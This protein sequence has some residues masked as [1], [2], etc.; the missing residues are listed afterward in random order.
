MSGRKPNGPEWE[1]LNSLQSNLNDLAAIIPTL[2]PTASKRAMSRIEELALGVLRLRASMPKALPAITDT[3][4]ELLELIVAIGPGLNGKAAC[5]A[6][7][8]VGEA[9][10]RTMEEIDPVRT[11]RTV[12]DP[13]MPEAAGRLV[14]IALLAQ[15]RLP[16]AEVGQMYGSGCYAIYYKG[17][18]PY[19]AAV[20]DTETPIYVGKAD[21]ANREARQ[22]R[23]QGPQL[24]GRLRDH[25]RMIMAVEKWAEEHPDP[26]NFP[27]HIADFEYRRLVVATNAQLVAE[28][29]LIQF[30]RP[31]WNREMAICWGISKHGDSAEKRSND[32]APWDVLHPGRAWAMHESLADSKTPD[33]IKSAIDD[34]FEIHPPYR[35][36]REIIDKFLGEFTQEA[37]ERGTCDDADEEGAEGEAPEV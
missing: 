1:A 28:Q 37:V 5:A 8:R 30:F 27:L 21:P 12:F 17:D 24:T 31:I 6:L 34:H 19:Y 13:A 15:P 10:T 36:I 2:N 35:D 33:E 9:I 3:M 4:A 26:N 22:P 7:A 18:H 25:R 16:L 32:R 20:S 11:P 29:Y 23:N 14:A